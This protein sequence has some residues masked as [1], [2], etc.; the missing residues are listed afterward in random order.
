[1]ILGLDSGGD[2]L[3]SAFIDLFLLMFFIRVDNVG[4]E[5]YVC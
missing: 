1:M 3:I 5:V 4:T 2:H